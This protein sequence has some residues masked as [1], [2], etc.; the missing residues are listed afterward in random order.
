MLV[1]CRRAVA[2][3]VVEKYQLV[4]VCGGVVGLLVFEE[5][6]PQLLGYVGAGDVV[7]VHCAAACFRQGRVAAWSGAFKDVV[8]VC[9]LLLSLV[10]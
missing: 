2:V 1:G 8:Y 10:L 7:S 9:S 4:D 5:P 3:S 6:P